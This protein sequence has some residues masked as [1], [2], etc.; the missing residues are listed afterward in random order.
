M[1][2]KGDDSDDSND[3]D[4]CLSVDSADSDDSDDCLSVHSDDSHH[5]KAKER[6]SEQKGGKA[7]TIHSEIK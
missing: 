3:S 2:G 4:D 7:S 5:S 1:Q 6:F